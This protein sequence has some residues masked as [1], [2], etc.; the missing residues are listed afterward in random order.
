M[1]FFFIKETEPTVYGTCRLLVA[2]E[3]FLG[4]SGTEVIPFSNI[5]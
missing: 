2:I 4:D 5:A 1:I 3:E